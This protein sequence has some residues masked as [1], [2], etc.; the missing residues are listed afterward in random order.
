MSAAKKNSSSTSV[1]TFDL[2]CNLLRLKSFPSKRYQIV[3][4]CHHP[5]KQ[6]WA[7]QRTSCWTEF[8][9]VHSL[10]WHHLSQGMD[11]KTDHHFGILD[12]CKHTI[13]ELPHHCYELGRT[14]KLR[15]NFP[16]TLLTDCIKCFGKVNKGHVEV[17]VLF[18]AFLLKLPCCDD[19]VNCSSVLSESSLAFR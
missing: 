8:R 18:L 11:Q 14:A 13:V 9:L 12:P 7:W 15:H 16:K 19:H 5:G 3:Y 4:H 2:A 10:A 6:M 17:H 1:C